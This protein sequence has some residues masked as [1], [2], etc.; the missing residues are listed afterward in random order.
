[1]KYT[2]KFVTGESVGIEVSAELEALLKNEDRLEYNNDHANTRRHVSM[3][4]VQEFG[5]AAFIDTKMDTTAQALK[6]IERAELLRA[7]RL[8]TTEQK[9]LIWQVFFAERSL[10]SLSVEM[11]VSYQAI[12]NRLE[13]A[14]KKL[15]KNL[16]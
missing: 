11:G 6:H 15:E 10:R 2:Y 5:G 12:Q 8:L 4:T 7:M 9:L 16:P 13:K 1:M 14:I 3:N